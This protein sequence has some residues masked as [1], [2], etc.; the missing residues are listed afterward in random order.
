MPHDPIFHTAGR[1]GYNLS[2]ATYST[3]FSDTFAVPADC[4]PAIGTDMP[5]TTDI[6]TYLQAVEDLR[7]SHRNAGGGKTV[8]S[9]VIGG[10]TDTDRLA[11]TA[12]GYF[13]RNPHAFCALLRIADDELWLVATPEVLIKTDAEHLE[14][15]ALAGTRPAGTNQPWDSKNITEQRIVTDY[16][17]GRWA[18]LDLFADTVGPDTLRSGNIEHLCTRISAKRTNVVSVSE[19]IDAIAPTPAVCGF[20]LDLARRNIADH[21]NYLRGLYAGYIAVTDPAGQLSAYVT[22]RCAR[23]NPL[24]GDFAV[25]V[26]SGIT[27]DSVPEH[28]LIETDMKARTIL[29]LLDPQSIQTNPIIKP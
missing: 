9:R 5:R 11:E 23:I 21:E 4:P 17:T 18:A 26:G 10:K 13:E 19:A 8:L 24:N 2:V 16:I 28:E 29:S 7:H 27:A 3:R 25:I 22:L 14:T 1:D 6:P 20:P 15:M 12:V